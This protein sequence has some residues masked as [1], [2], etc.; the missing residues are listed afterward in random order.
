MHYQLLNILRRFIKGAAGRWLATLVIVLPLVFILSRYLGL[1]RNIT[2][3][4]MFGALVLILLMWGIGSLRKV[5]NRKRSKDF[6]NDLGRHSQ[7]TAASQEEI[8]QAVEDLSQQWGTAMR[9]LKERRISIYEMPWFLLIGEPQSGKTTTLNK[10][11]LE[12]PIGQEAI[13]GTGG[14]RNCDWWFT[15]EAVILDTAGRLTFQ[16]EEASDK[17][18][19]DAFLKML[20]KHRRECPV[21]GV[22]VVI[23]ATSLTEDTLEHQREK[24]MNIRRHLENLQKTLNVRFPIFVLITKADR[25]LG[26]SEFFGSLH[27]DQHGQIFGWSNPEEDKRWDPET[28]P[29]ILGEMTGRMHKLRLRLMQEARDAQQIDRFFVF[30]E[31]LEALKTPLHTY[32]EIIF[33]AS[34]RFHEHFMFRGFYLTSGLQEGRP[35]AVACRDLLRV[36]VG[37][38]RQ[39]LEEPRNRPHPSLRLLHPRLLQQEGLS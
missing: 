20:G 7:G 9:E 12:F 36:Q 35:I 30:P 11:S 38:A 26:F 6:E 39:V 1:S 21:N 15:E 33:K 34:S 3:F 4:V 19:W 8:R 18:E 14:T 27:P 32:L 29:E 17:H 28:F 23:P 25:I 13:S 5:G 2:V 24:A 10:S 37:D 22:L 16:Q 31:E